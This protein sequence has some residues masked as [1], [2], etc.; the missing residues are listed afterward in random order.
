MQARE[1]RA[2]LRVDDKI[3]PEGSPQR[4]SSHRHRAGNNAQKS[5]E[6]FFIIFENE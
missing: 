2:A 1:R 6:F 4:L 3:A 5:N